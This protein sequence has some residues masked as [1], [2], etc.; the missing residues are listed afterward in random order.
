MKFFHKKYLP[1]L[2]LFAGVVSFSLFFFLTTRPDKPH[3]SLTKETSAQLS[4]D[5]FTNELFLSE[6]S[7]STINLHYTLSNPKNYGISQYPITF[8]DF[9]E[10]GLSERI[11]NLENTFTF[12]S[13]VNKDDLTDK[14]KLT[15]DILSSYYTTEMSSVPYTYY[16][17]LLSPTCGIQAQLPI[18]L[19]EY[20]VH[21]EQDIKDY[22]ALLKKLDDYYESILAFENTKSA[23]GLFMPDYAVDSVID[24]CEEFIK[25]PDDSYLIQTFDEKLKAFKTLSSEQKA[26]YQEENRDCLYTEVIPAYQLLIKGL[27]VLKGTGKNELGLC[28]YPEGKKYYEYLVRYSTGSSRTIPELE[29][30][31]EVQIYTDLSSLLHL[32]KK[33]PSAL[34]DAAHY[35]FSLSDPAIIL[36]DLKNKITMDFPDPPTVSCSIKYV[37][38]SLEKYAS[39]AFYLTPAIDQRNQNTIYIN[40]GN[41]LNKLDLYTTLAHEGYPGHLFQNIYFDTTNP[42]KVRSI[43][44]FGGYTEGWATYVEMLSYSYADITPAVSRL[45]QLNNAIML[46]LYARIDMGIHYDGWKL[47]E[48]T[49]FLGDFGITNV[50]AIQEIYHVIIEEPANYLQY[51]IGYLE[52]LSLKDT[53]KEALGSNF[54]LKNFH[55][56]V[57]DLGPAPFSVIETYENNWI[58]MQQKNN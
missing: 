44:N 47:E 27:S 22:L 42:D 50:G 16:S 6:V 7:S 41:H 33:N 54:N 46:S 3:E 31:T 58:E 36:E 56:F 29:K 30:M 43:L 20:T 49:H 39:P 18:L 23:K 14:Q 48:V 1:F 24:Q 13:R 38:P 51:E 40:S 45:L 28:Y 12:L 25:E 57:L 53:A 11:H 10:K 32:S 52:F 55:K 9:S 17:E 8:G 19:A 4:F 2:V 5:R 34:A 26:F 15:Y 35:D 37:P 21:T